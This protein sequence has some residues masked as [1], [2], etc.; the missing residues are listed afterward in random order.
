MHIQYLSKAIPMVT[1]IQQGSREKSIL[2]NR[3][4]CYEEHT[5]G[6]TISLPNGQATLGFMTLLHYQHLQL[7]FD[8]GRHNKKYER[9]N[10]KHQNY[11]RDTYEIL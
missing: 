10:K 4:C 1:D 9:S 11:G 3:H 8:S 7:S 5:R 6:H 2:E